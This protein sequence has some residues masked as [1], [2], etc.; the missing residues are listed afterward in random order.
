MRILSLHFQY[1]VFKLPLKKV[2]FHIFLFH[3]PRIFDG[4]DLSWSHVIC[5]LNNQMSNRHLLGNVKQFF[6]SGCAT[7]YTCH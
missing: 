2:L 5:I 6:R 7:L 4:L 1:S 3:I